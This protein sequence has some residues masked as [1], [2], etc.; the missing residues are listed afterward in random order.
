MITEAQLLRFVIFHGASPCPKCGP[1]QSMIMMIWCVWAEI[2]HENDH[3]NIVIIYNFII[4]NEDK[5]DAIVSDESTKNTAFAWRVVLHFASWS[6]V[7]VFYVRC[8]ETASHPLGSAVISVTRR[9]SDIL[10]KLYREET[11]KWYVC[12]L[13]SIAITS[14]LWND[15]RFNL[16]SITSVIAFNVSPYVAYYHS[17]S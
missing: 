2:L 3:I 11:I 1:L 12:Y 7:L 5:Y 16:I 17:T 13:A 4:Q 6:P 14:S 8:K 9:L 15:R 10:W